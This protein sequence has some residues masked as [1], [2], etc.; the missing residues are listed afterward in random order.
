MLFLLHMHICFSPSSL[1]LIQLRF[2]D[3]FIHKW[4]LWMGSPPAQRSAID[5]WLCARSQTRARAQIKKQQKWIDEN[6]LGVNDSSS[7]FFFSLSLH[8]LLWVKPGSMCCF[9]HFLGRWRNRPSFDDGKTAFISQNAPFLAAAN[10]Y[11]MCV[12]S[13]S[14]SS[15]MC[16]GAITLIYCQKRWRLCRVRCA[17]FIVAVSSR[18]IN[19]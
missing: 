19:L 18:S 14:R 8:L 7:S 10:A 12:Q 15:C 4:I 3:G 17:S 2:Y 13:S 9:C 11:A 5:N 6:R 16:C 1:Q